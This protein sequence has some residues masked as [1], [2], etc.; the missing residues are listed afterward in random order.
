MNKYQTTKLPLK[1]L[2]NIDNF[3]ESGEYTSRVD[4]IKEAI[5]EKIRREEK[6]EEKG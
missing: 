3:V 1:L 6:I 2:E 5:R 4:F